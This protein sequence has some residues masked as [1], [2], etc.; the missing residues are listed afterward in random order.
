MTERRI[1]E[2]LHLR[3]LTKKYGELAAVDDL[4]LTIPAGS[5]FALLGASSHSLV[6][7]VAARP[8]PCEWSPA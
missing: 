1:V 7:P 8:P 4:T 3:N 5:F 6:H 2:D